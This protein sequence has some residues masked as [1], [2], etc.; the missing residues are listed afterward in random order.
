MDKLSFLKGLALGLAGKPLDFAPKSEPVAYLYNGVRLPALPEWDKEKYPYAV[1]RKNYSRYWLE[2]TQNR[3]YADKAGVSNTPVRIA[4]PYTQYY[5]R[6][7]SE[8]IFYREYGED[9]SLGG[10]FD[11]LNDVVWTNF[12]LKAG[13]T[14]VLE[15]SEPVAVYE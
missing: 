11:P 3:P 13:S 9:Y 10:F 1:I 6:D 4:L 7:G 14:V 5:F 8:W 2:F 15:A 12:D